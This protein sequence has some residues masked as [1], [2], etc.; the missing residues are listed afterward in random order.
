MESWKKEKTVILKA[1]DTEILILMCYAH[2]SQAS[3]NKWIMNIDSKR[4]TNVK[5][6]QD[7]LGELV[8]DFYQLTTVKLAVL[9][10]LTQLI[11]EKLD[12]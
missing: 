5:A 3:T 4:Y 8:C 2:S 12:Y 6:I 1:T 11:D 9:Q 7:H 10:R